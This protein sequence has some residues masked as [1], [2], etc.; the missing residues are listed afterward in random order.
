MGNKIESTVIDA[1]TQ[2]KQLDQGVVSLESTL[3]SLGISSLDAIT[4]VYDIEEIFDVEV[5]NDELASLQ[6]V[7]DIVLGIDR[8]LNQAVPS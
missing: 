1:I 5:P 6:T 7:Q 8:L 4:I 2:H 3:D